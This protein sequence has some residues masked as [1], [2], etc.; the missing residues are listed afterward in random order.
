MEFRAALRDAGYIVTLPTVRGENGQ[1]GVFTMYYDEVSDVIKAAEYLK[2]LP[3]VDGNR[4]FVAGYSV[5]GT[6]TM[7]SSELYPHF[8]AA[9]SI[10]G[11]A[12]LATY[13]PYAK[14]C[15]SRCTV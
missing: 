13:L 5:G 6:L 9:A 2:S 4:L 12:D 3:T 10:S 15:C 8:R 7:L 1:H 11:T 14:G